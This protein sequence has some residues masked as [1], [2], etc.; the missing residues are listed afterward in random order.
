MQ[1]D[2]NDI[3]IPYK[4]GAEIEKKCTIYFLFTYISSASSKYG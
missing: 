1:N 2:F 4:C 3:L